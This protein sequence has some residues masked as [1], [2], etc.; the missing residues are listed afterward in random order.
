MDEIFSLPPQ[1]LLSLSI[2]LGSCSGPS[3]SY[4]FHFK[5]TYLSSRD[6]VLTPEWFKSLFAQFWHFSYAEVESRDP[7]LQYSLALVTNVW[8]LECSEV[9]PCYFW[10]SVI[11]GNIAWG[12]FCLGTLVI[13][14]QPPCCDEAQA[15][16]RGRCRVNDLVGSPDP[17][18]TSMRKPSRGLPQLS[19]RQLAESCQLP[20]PPRKTT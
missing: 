15:T 8:S 5:Q 4:L 13:G 14:T 18:D 19:R 20:E 2:W 12:P 1:S 7:P 6:N 9:M 10:G 16:W 11:Q 3:I 17:P